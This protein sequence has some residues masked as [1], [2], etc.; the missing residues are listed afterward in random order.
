MDML[1]KV[2]KKLIDENQVIGIEDLNV[3]GMMK[4]KNLSKAIQELSLHEF[5]RQ[6]IYK[7]DWNNRN[8]V[9]VDRWFPSSK[10]C[11]CCKHKKVDLKLSER[12]WICVKCNTTHDRDLN[13]AKNIELEAIRMLKVGTSSAEPVTRKSHKRSVEGLEVKVELVSTSIPRIPLKQKGDC[14]SNLCVN[15]F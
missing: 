9:I 1:H 6:L 14:V 13:A 7:A 4:N 8:L 11:H 2:S 3:K 10:T 5:K 15:K 12:T